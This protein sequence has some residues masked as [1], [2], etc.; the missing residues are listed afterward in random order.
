M[1]TTTRLWNTVTD[2]KPLHAA[3]GA[4]DLLVATLRR[5]PG[6]VRA[7][8]HPKRSR[9]RLHA[10]RG[11]VRALP[12]RARAAARARLGRAADAYDELAARGTTVI[13]REDSTEQLLARA[14][15]TVRRARAS[16][17]TTRAQPTATPHAPK[18]TRTAARRTGRTA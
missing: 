3:A 6:G 18:T 8:L 5:V 4:G 17:Q 10:L 12:S 15:R 16:R 7:E 14:E 11:T 1:A 9:D 13:C 2:S